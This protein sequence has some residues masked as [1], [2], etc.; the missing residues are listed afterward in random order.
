M[1]RSN[2]QARNIIGKYLHEQ[3]QRQLMSHIGIMVEHPRR[4]TVWDCIRFQIE[5]EIN[6]TLS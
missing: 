3:V 6:F 5:D 4:F 1:S 2:T